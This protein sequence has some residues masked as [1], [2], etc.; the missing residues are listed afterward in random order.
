MTDFGRDTLCIESLRTGRYASGVRLIAQRLFHRLITP[1]GMLRDDPNFGDDLAS[2]CGEA[3]SDALRAAIGPRVENEL[4]K[5][6]Q[7][8]SVRCKVDA[9]EIG[10]SEW[11]YTL[12]ITVQ[13]AVGPF[14]FRV[15][16]NDA[17]V[18]YLGLE[19]L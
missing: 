14:R 13:S 4:R 9:T 3:D 6:E 11:S 2:M 8:E 12:T 1:R 7:V 18:D 16:V 10:P 5:D 15:S 17:T 19:S